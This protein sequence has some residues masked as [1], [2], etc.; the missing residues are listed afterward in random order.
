MQIKFRLHDRV[1]TF[2]A[3]WR[4]SA[5]AD[6]AVLKPFAG[7]VGGYLALM[8]FLGHSSGWSWVALTIFIVAMGKMVEALHRHVTVPAELLLALTTVLILLERWLL[9]MAV[10]PL[11]GAPGRFSAVVQVPLLGLLLVAFM[12]LLIRGEWNKWGRLFYLAFLAGV[13]ASVVVDGNALVEVIFAV[14]LFFALMRATAWLEELS[15]IECWIALVAAW[16]LYDFTAVAE[17]LD[18]VHLESGWLFGYLPAFVLLAWKLYLLAVMVKV[19]VVLVY[20]HAS[21]KRKLSIAAFFQSTFPQLIQLAILLLVFLMVVSGWQARNLADAVRQET[22]RLATSA[23][24]ELPY[25]VF[26][27]TPD[28]DGVRFEGRDGGVF[29]SLRLSSD[30]GMLVTATPEGDS[31]CSAG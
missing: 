6:P 19:P 4:W 2:L 24:S 17:P 15:Q 14:I 13:W 8:Y 11:G 25:P 12:M 26:E 30:L 28:A 22:R 10:D 16:L 29:R 23:V 20:N 9:D 3:E 27:V 31:T 1:Q 21:L 5:L 7:V 18:A